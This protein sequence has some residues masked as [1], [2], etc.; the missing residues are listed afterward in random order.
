MD[1]ALVAA[2]RTDGRMSVADLAKRVGASRS[3]VSARLEQLKA[4][5]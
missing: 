3:A 2:L 1:D 5:G 4:D